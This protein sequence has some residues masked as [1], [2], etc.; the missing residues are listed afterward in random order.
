MERFPDH[1]RVLV[2][3]DS[4][5][6]NGTWIAHVYDHYLRHFPGADI[7]FFNAGVSGGSCV[8]ALR[9]YD[10]GNG[11]NYRPTHAV[12]M[13]GVND[14][15]RGLYEYAPDAAEAPDPRVGERMARI[16]AYRTR[17]REL[18]RLLLSRGVKLTFV[19]PT[20]YDESQHPRE[21]DKVGCDAALE[22]L[23]EF[24]R[25]LAEETGS[26]FVN[27]HAPLRLLNAVKTMT[28]PDRV[29]PTPEGH[30]C[31]ARLFLAAQGLAEAPTMDTLDSLPDP[32]DLLPLNRARF[33]AEKDVRVLWNVEWLVLRDQTGDEDAR[34][35]YLREFRAQ[36]H[37][38][39]YNRIIDRY[40]ELDGD[41]ARCQARERA[42][43]EA[44]LAR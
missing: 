14:V 21:L 28:G 23:G 40:F 3:G 44:L 30:V 29:H 38:E 1:A 16:D 26:D 4:I 27:I 17:L 33:E 34:R 9:Y 22:Y 12:I 41:L 8:S 31:M 20:G 19:T 39:V 2:I 11:G 43:L 35:A 10:R 5:T 6:A 15:G 18:A 25:R 24:N 36:P 32:D 37:A 13:L 42:A 7:R